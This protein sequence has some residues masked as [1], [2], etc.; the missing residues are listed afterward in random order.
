VRCGI[1]L[2][3]KQPFGLG[4]NGRGATHAHPRFQRIKGDTVYHLFNLIL[5]HN[6]NLLLKCLYGHYTR[7]DCGLEE[8][9]ESLGEIE[10]IINYFLS[11]IP[12]YSLIGG[13]GD[14]EM[15]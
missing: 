8:F 1:K 11:K 9:K 6:Y 12:P 10:L 5:L 13:S 7:G 3:P 4:R 14:G 15:G 2:S